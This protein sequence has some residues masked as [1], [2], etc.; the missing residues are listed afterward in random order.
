MTRQKDIEVFIRDVPEAD[1]VRWLTHTLGPLRK[2]ESDPPI[3]HATRS[4]HVLSVV[5]QSA[6]ADGTYTGVMVAPNATPWET[7]IAFARAAFKALKT[8]VRCD[9]GTQATMPWRWLSVRHSGETLV[10]WDAPNDI[11]G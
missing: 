3:Y 6:V 10:D 11:P 1:I 5:L 4:Q 7:D 8:E 2:V 9:P